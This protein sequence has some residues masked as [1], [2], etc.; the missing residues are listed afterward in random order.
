MA[1][2]GQLRISRRDINRKYGELMMIR[3]QINLHSDVLD[4]PEFFFELPEGKETYTTVAGYLQTARRARILNERLDLLSSLYTMI[5]ED[6]STNVS[7]R[8]EWLIVGLI[9]VE[10]CVAL[11]QHH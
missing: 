11:V 3:T 4:L 1:A 2:H 6:R 7:H 5:S 8:L 9:S 10:I